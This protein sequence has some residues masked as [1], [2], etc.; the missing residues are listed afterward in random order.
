[1][2]GDRKMSKPTEL[3]RVLMRRDKLTLEEAEELV[4]EMRKAVAD[5]AD[6]EEVLYEEG[7][8]PDYILDMLG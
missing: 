3:I 1:M 4:A 8:E 7:L 6:P 5:G 2:I